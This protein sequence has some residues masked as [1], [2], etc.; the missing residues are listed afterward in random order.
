MW[1]KLKTLVLATVVGVA[2]LVP[3]FGDPRSTPV[4]HP[5]WARMLL[6][7]LDMTDAVRTSAQAS[8][9]FAT[10]AW[11]DSLTYPAERYLRADGAVVRVEAG[12]PVV[13]AGTAPAEVVYPLAIVQPGDYQLRARLAGAP[14]APATAEVLP[15]AGGK[16][17]RTFTL[18]PASQISWVF[19]G[20]THLD[21]GAYTASFLLPPGCSLSQVEVAPPCVNSIEPVGGWKQA[22]TT[23]TQDLAVTALKAIDIEN[24]LPP[25]ATPIEVTGADFQV[26]APMEAVEARA[27]ASGLE[28]MTLRA[29]RRGLR[30]MVSVDL[31]E[32]GLYSVSAFVT[33]GAGQRWLADG[34]R[35]AIICPGQGMS[36]RTVMTQAFSAGRHTLILTLG[37]GAALERVRLERRKDTPADYVAT[38]RRL[39]F[40]PGPDGPVSR[41]KALDGMRFVRERRRA[42][43]GAMCGDSVRLDESAPTAL[44]T[45]IAGT[46]QP[47]APPPPA[48]QPPAVEPPIG[49]PILPP[50]E[51]ATPTQPGGGV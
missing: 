21:P 44:P 3:L 20:S 51:P 26:E 24:E 25:S 27:K 36:W 8:Q 29:S 2:A 11:R 42:L 6:R 16:A 43:F 14:G 47:P 33:P 1:G 45:Q 34:C 50:Q 12:Q 19:A 41:E 49:P 38:I 9:V 40:D 4:T 10:L 37:D 22:A 39:G 23:T 13:V 31:P 28:S 7:S 30:A 46:V 18:I 5:L 15:M 48:V 32:A 17:L 35:K